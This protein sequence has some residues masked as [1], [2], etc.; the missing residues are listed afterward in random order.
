[1]SIHLQ[2]GNEAINSYKR[3]AYTAWHAIAELVDNSTQ[4]Y[5]DNK[6]KLDKASGNINPVLTV[7]IDY[8]PESEFL[9]VEDNA[10]G[11]SYKELV[12]ALKVAHP[13]ANTSGRSKY[14]MG[15]KT[16][17]CWIGNEW[18]VVTKKL[19]ETTE[20]T[21]TVDVEKIAGGDNTLKESQK[22]DLPKDSHYTIIEIKDH[23]RK[24]KGQTL[25]KIERYLSSM[26][27]EDFRKGF[28]NLIWRD[29]RINWID[30]DDRLRRDHEGNLY[31]KPFTFNIKEDGETKSVRGWI[32]IFEKGSRKDAGFS[33]LHSGRV[34]RGYPDSWR[35]NSVFGQDQGSNDL[36]NQRLV[37]EIHFD[38]FDVSH[39]KDDI[40]W[41]GEQEDLVQAK[42][43][44]ICEDYRKEANTP[45]KG[46]VDQRGPSDMDVEEAV[47]A[48]KQELESKELKDI[49]GTNP[50]LTKKLIDNVVKSVEA[51][52]LDNFQETF[53]IKIIDGLTVKV[54]I[55][56]DMSINDPYVTIDSAKAKEV[57]VIVN[58]A[59]PHWSQLEDNS[60][61]VLN[62]LRHCVYDG[63][64][65]WQSRKFVKNL[66]PDSIKILKDRL[67]RLPL[68]IERSKNPSEE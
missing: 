53:T 38:D 58:R 4:S 6:D 11:M 51:Y 62:Y 15:L 20:Y 30:L 61:S 40:L 52:V 31:Q 7:K 46:K 19:G 33:I 27:R 18:T 60:L 50:M 67:L 8:D 35:P 65:E 57:I 2:I 41:L 47:D 63:V 26:Y 55:E 17:A 44:E 48:L 12:N 22:T 34:I 64:A 36:A 1:M 45:R 24:F 3:L 43:Q 14:G 39:T 68:D 66:L 9:R 29:Q 16:S 10:M 56:P 59:H 21:V 23:N 32:G 28:L 42:L 5:F 37:G 54:F 13:P 25:G 49:V